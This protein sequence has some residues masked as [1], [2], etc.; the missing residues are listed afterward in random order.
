MRGPS[1][2]PIPVE[3]ELV[4]RGTVARTST[5][6][7]ILQPI[8]IVAVNA[9]LSGILLA[10]KV[11]EGTRVEKGQELAELDA[12]ELEAQARSAQSSLTLAESNF[13]RSEELYRQKIITQAEYDRDQAA[14]EASR[15]SLDQLKTRLGYATIVA[16]VSG[17]VTEKRVEAGDA[18]ST[19]TRMFTIADVSTLVTR[20]QVSELEVRSLHAGDSVHLT[21]DALAGEGVSARI[22]RIFPSADSATRLIPVEIALTGR[23]LERLRPGYT[24]RATFLLDR[25]DDA[26]LVPSRAIS[27]PVGARAAFV[28]AAGLVERRAVR[29]GPDLDGRTEIFDGL[30][31]GDSVIV[32]GSAVLREGAKVRVVPPLGDIAQPTVETVKTD[33]PPGPATP[34]GGD[35]R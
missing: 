25:R 6:A 2:K 29:V 27:G 5:I 24:V 32:S 35:S 18:V 16:P 22:R 33:T 19:N 34:A 15:A 26:L 30:A 14:L 12:R 9:Q 21:V 10:V 4:G 11:E 1:D 31:E 17:I 3:V 13:K 23:V 8:R 20:V 28:V 7:G